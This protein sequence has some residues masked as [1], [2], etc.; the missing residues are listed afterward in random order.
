MDKKFL[1]AAFTLTGTIIGAG[2]L[3]LPYVFAK[4]GFLVGIFWLIVMGAVMIFVNLSMGEVTLRTKGDHQLPG[5]ANKYLGKWGKRLMF[6]AVIIGIY[7]A[8]LAYLIGEGGSFAKLI[9]LNIPPII[10]GIVFWALMTALLGHGLKELKRIEVWGVFAII[11]IVIGMFVRYISKVDFS[12]LAVV[13][14]SNFIFPIGVVLFAMLGFTSIPEL[15]KEIKGKEK[16]LKR[17]II[18]GSLIPIGL[19]IL[20]SLIFIGVLGVNVSEVATLS[21]GPIITILGIFTMLTSYFVLSFDLHDIFKYDL[22][23]SKFV[24]VLLTSLIPL[25]LYILVMVFDLASFNTILGIGGTVSGG[26]TGILIL[27]MAYRAKKSVDNK[28]PEINIPINWPI[29][30]V[31]SVIFLMAIILQLFF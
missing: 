13:D 10:Y 2:I 28:N 5:Y 1:A 7:S 22:K 20:F 29:I 3:G 9:P 26:L 21:F 18:I 25:A 31:F 17:A 6:L 19:Y 4:S 14:T 24:S 8:L 12:N 23:T 30:I 11:A 15:R 27:L 16:L